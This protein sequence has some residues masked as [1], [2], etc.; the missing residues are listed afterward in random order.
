MKN[1]TMCR[2]MR[3]NPEAW[4][5]YLEEGCYP[6][7]LNLLVNEFFLVGD[8]IGKRCNEYTSDE[9]LIRILKEELRKKIDFEVEEIETEYVT[10]ED[11]TKIYLQREEHTGYYHL[12]RQDEDGMWSHKYPK[13]LPTRQDSIGQN[14]EDSDTMVEA[15]F[16]GWCFLLRKRTS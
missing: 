1:V 5:E 15:P 2:N 12:L 4:S 16:K 3:Y 7:A 11:E 8:L 6:Y 9:D 13:E 14:I 10:K